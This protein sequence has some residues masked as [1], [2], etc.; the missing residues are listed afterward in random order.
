MDV[1]E[2][3]DDDVAALRAYAAVAQPSAPLVIVVPA[4][5]WAW[6][7]KDVRLGHRRRYTRERL[8]AA[9]TAAGLDVERVTHF[10]SWLAVVAFVGRKTPLKRFLSG[11]RDE[12]GTAGTKLNRVLR[13]VGATE[14]AALR[15][16]DLP[17][18]LS[19]LAIARVPDRDQ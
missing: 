19:I 14:R 2:H 15:F 13:A 1:I 17:F 12:A 9:L 4:Y 8:R 3:L 7:D 16:T 18:G 5:D 6:S 10:H 11:G